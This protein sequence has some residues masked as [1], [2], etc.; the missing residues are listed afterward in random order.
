VGLPEEHG[1]TPD[2]LKINEIKGQKKKVTAGRGINRST[3]ALAGQGRAAKALTP[4]L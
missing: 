2:E 1:Y 3:H 4:Y